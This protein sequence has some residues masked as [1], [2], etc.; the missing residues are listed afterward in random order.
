M[1]ER[2]RSARK[3]AARVSYVETANSSEDS[4]DEEASTSAKGLMKHK[5]GGKG[6]G[7]CGLAHRR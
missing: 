2:N 5:R 4:G 1:T 7:E 3:A 6:K